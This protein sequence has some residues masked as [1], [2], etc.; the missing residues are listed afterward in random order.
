MDSQSSQS[1]STSTGTS[2]DTSHDSILQGDAWEISVLYRATDTHTADA[3]RKTL[4][5]DEEHDDDEEDDEETM[6][7]D[8]DDM[9]LSEHQVYHHEGA[10]PLFLAIEENDWNNALSL[11]Q[12]SPKQVRTWVKSTGTVGTTF[13]WSVW[14]RLPVHEACRRQPPAWLISQLLSVFPESAKKTTQFGELPLHLAVACGADPDVV[15]L[16]IAANFSSV[17]TMDQSGRTPLEILNET[18]L[19]ELEDQMVVLENLKRSTETY[20]AVFT[21]HEAQVKRLRNEHN[22]EL[23]KIEKQHSSTLKVEQH[24]HDKLGQEVIR[25]SKIV[26]ELATLSLEQS[27]KIETFDKR[28][29]SWKEKNLELGTQLRKSQD[30]HEDA[31]QLINALQD[32]VVH[33]NEEIVALKKCV[34]QLSAD[35]QKCHESQ[36]LLEP[37]V[38][39]AKA[40]LHQTVSCL[41]Q[42][43]DRIE[44]NSL[45]FKALLDA[46]GI[47]P[48]IGSHEDR[49]EKKTDGDPKECSVKGERILE[50]FLQAPAT[51]LHYKISIPTTGPETKVVQNS[52]HREDEKDFATF[53]HSLNSEE[54]TSPDVASAT[55][56]SL[57]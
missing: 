4:T 14:K 36:M 3:T 42:L 30:E 55:A 48:I 57:E 37:N 16:L 32:L 39:Q 21:A 20:Q 11:A 6:G 49:E 24:Q 17:A 38:S 25:L 5:S 46:R 35:M 47:A 31:Q 56:K 28:E 53:I 13:D 19:L 41:L 52:P 44:T 40:H 50:P 15:N 1:T 27:N 22:E 2:A 12:E 43:Y 10:T 54:E 29:T 34:T 33:K 45:D 51:D 23:S 9:L 18:D 26:S 7:S 8:E